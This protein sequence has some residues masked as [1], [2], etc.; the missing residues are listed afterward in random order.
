[1]D[2]LTVKELAALAGTSET[3]IRQELAAGRIPANKRGWIWVIDT[4]DARRWL[5]SRKPPK[6]E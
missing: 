5:D 6:T 3:Y 2:W 4:E 1:M